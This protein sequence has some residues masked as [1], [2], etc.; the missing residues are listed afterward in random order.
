MLE[1]YSVFSF[2]NALVQT[3]LKQMTFIMPLPVHDVGKGSNSCGGKD[4]DKD[5]NDHDDDGDQQENED[6]N[7]DE[8]DDDV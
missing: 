5:E 7:D 2:V 6:D 1:S 3:L 8:D 4:S